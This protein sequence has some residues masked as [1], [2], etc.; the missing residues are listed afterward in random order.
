MTRSK[1]AGRPRKPP[2]LSRA[3]F[4]TVLASIFFV[5]SFVGILHHEPWRDELQAWMVA[6]DAHSLP[7]L[8]Q[9]VKYEGHPALWYIVLFAVTRVSDTPFAMAVVHILISTLTIAVFAGYTVLPRPPKVL[10]AFGYAAFF[11]FNLISRGYALG[12]LFVMAFCA[13]YPQRDRRLVQ[14]AL[15]LALMANTSPF[16]LML[17]LALGAHVLFDHLARF[18]RTASYRRVAAA[19]GLLLAGWILSVVQI[20]PEADSSFPV[21]Y[22]S[23]GFALKRLGFALSRILTSYLP[24]PDFSQPHF[25]NRT[26]F[27]GWAVLAQVALSLALF[28][29]FTA[30]FL[31][32][33]RL[34]LLYVGGTVLM[35]AFVYQTRLAFHRYGLHLFVLL[36]TCFC[37]EPCCED[38]L[39]TPWLRRV[40]E[41]VRP[42]AGRLFIALLAG[43]VYA[44]VGAYLEDLARPFSASTEAAAFLRAKGVADL[45]IVGYADYIVS[46]LAALL[47]KRIY[48]PQRADYG[49]FIVWN[50]G[51]KRETD[52]GAIREAAAFMLAKGEERFLWIADIQPNRTRDRPYGPSEPPAAVSGD[53]IQWYEGGDGLI[54][55]VHVTLLG[56]IPPGI[57]DDEHY[58]IY[59]VERGARPLG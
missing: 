10:F 46:P 19:V 33:R 31:R 20:Y 30:G 27:S 21:S 57:T 7:E 40:S 6:S 1:A 52:L 34:A 39:R 51:R 9:N 38:D 53:Q 35:L 17:S 3:W 26:V 59:L 24:L 22:A 32:K 18:G 36:V 2:R 54:P 42:W 43:G 8:F 12:L 13:L 16:G 55:G 15:V 28:L 56:K 41:R 23:G 29:V 47:G 45:E 11:E 4:A 48:Y 5:L 50:R 25:W 44:G 49:R 58:V 14:C 37:L